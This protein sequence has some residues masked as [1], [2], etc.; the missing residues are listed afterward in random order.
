MIDEAFERYWLGNRRELLSQNK[1]YREIEESYKIRSGFDWLL[2]A[3]PVV[4]GMIV[5][6]VVKTESEMLK[7]LIS[8]GVTIVVFLVCVW[9]KS[10]ISGHRSLDEVEKEVKEQAYE[11]FKRK[12]N[13][14]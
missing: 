2:W 1:E 9:I 12:L 10:V 5:F 8:A 7:W 13:Q 6:S 14:P 4:V 3:L 11:A